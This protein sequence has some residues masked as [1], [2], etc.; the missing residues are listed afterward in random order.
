M[1]RKPKKISCFILAITFLLSSQASFAQSVAKIMVPP[2]G[3]SKGNERARKGLGEVLSS[4]GQFDVI[5][6]QAVDTYLRGTQS[7]KQSKEDLTEA[8]KLLKKGVLAYR[9]LDMKS[10]ITHFESAQQEFRSHLLVNEAFIGLRVVK[11]YLAMVHLADSKPDEARSELMEA[12]R[13]DVERD[14][15]EL[16]SKI[17]SDEVRS[18]YSNVRED[19]KKLEAGSIQI[20]TKPIGATVYLNGEPMGVT[21]TTISDLPVGEH[22]VRLQLDGYRDFFASQVVVEGV[23]PL[24]VAMKPELGMTTEALFRP[25]SPTQEINVSRL[26]FLDEMSLK[27][28]ADMILFADPGSGEVRAQIYDLRNQSRTPVENGHDPE[29]LVENLMQHISSEGYVSPKMDDPPTM[30]L[31]QSPQVPQHLQPEPTL[32]RQAR[33]PLANANRPGDQKLWYE[34]L[35][36]WAAIGGGLLLVGGGV[37]LLSGAGKG[38][39]STNTLT[40]HVP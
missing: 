26:S 38:N 7:E 32:S 39:P 28:G 22:F 9:A 13:M 21:P 6:F 19:V 25:L 37:F 16:S 18:L 17:Y 1:V 29:T 30:T 3:T 27:L 20:M 23:N 8:R 11:F 40:I 24:D 34:K 35:W 5:D 36:V 4:K 10:A 14:S 33:T 31:S 15:R 2:L 12:I